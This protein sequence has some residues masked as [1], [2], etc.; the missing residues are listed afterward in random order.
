M[1]IGMLG[2]GFP[3]K[4][5]S[6]LKELFNSKKYF[7]SGYPFVVDK[8]GNFIIHPK[9]EGKNFANEEF[10]K[11]LTS[12]GTETGKTF[13]E[14]EGRQKFQY[15]RY[16]PAIESYISVSIYEDELYSIVRQQRNTIILAILI[17]MGIF[18]LINMQISRSIANGLR[19]GV[20][21]AKQI[22]EGDLNATIELDQKD[23]VGELVH[24][25]NTMVARLRDIVG[26]ITTGANSIA[27]A[28]QQ[29][30]STAQQLSQGATEQASSVEEVSSTMEE[31][32][33]NISQNTD[34]ARETESISEVAL[35]GIEDVAGKST[36]AV[37]AT[38]IISD[39]IM[40]IND[41]A[42]QTNI[43]AL[44]A[45]VEAARAGEH[46]R[47]FA[48]VAAEVR[49]LAERSK[50]AADEI[51]G[52]AHRS[53]ELVESAGLKLNEM[54]PEVN[55]TTKLVQEI[56][57][58]S[59]EQSNG[60]GQVNSAIQQLN[61]VTQQNAAASEELATSAEELASQADQLKDLIMF[62]RIDSLKIEKRSA[63]KKYLQM[64]AKK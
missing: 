7:E 6:A 5:L 15:F 13:Y 38:R 53:V 42:F 3:E 26:N 39:K 35:R 63:T 19:K 48:V 1:V 41:I 24:A 36:Q 2:V 45:A 27:S 37:E 46:G 44:N 28:S 18:I 25:L 56:A 34:N 49:K 33:G 43:L 22:S 58:S 9:N 52:I 10:F 50:I 61:D 60:S 17:G 4:D 64:L 29:I 20:N 14:W 54:L 30:S 32:V 55:K 57:A 40:I 16:L 47:G 59:L 21:L 31:I 62:F 23:E 8:E 11:Q 12:A 51:V